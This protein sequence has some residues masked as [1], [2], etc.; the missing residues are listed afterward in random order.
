MGDESGD[1]ELDAGEV[2]GISFLGILNSFT[3][4][5]FSSFNFDFL[6]KNYKKD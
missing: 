2:D 6:K 5:S 4:S 1:D 3:S